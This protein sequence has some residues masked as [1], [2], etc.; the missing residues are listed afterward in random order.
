MKH[1]FGRSAGLLLFFSFCTALQLIPESSAPSVVKKNY[2][3]EIARFP[4][5]GLPGEH[6]YLA[7]AL[8]RLLLHT[9]SGVE[10][11]YLS[12]QEKSDRAFLN[13]REAERKK[14]L[15]NAAKLSSNSRSGLL[16][17]GASASAA[18]EEP[19][20]A[21][22]FIP[23]P[24][25][26][27]VKVL[28]TGGE[29]SE[30]PL[31]AADYCRKNSVDMLISGRIEPIGDLVYF[32]LSAY[33]HSRDAWERFYVSTSGFTSL[34]EALEQAKGAVREEVLGRPWSAL[35]LIT[36]RTDASIFID[37]N[38]SGIGAVYDKILEPGPHTLRV[39][40]EAVRR[41]ERFFELE[42]RKETRINIALESMSAP[43]L[44]LVSFPSG[45]DVY[46]SSRWVGKTPLFLPES[47]RTGTLRLVLNG[48]RTLMLPVSELEQG[49]N[50]FN[51]EKELYD[52]TGRMRQKK[53]SLYSAVGLFT[54]SLPLTMFSY[55][56]YADYWNQAVLYDDTGLSQKAVLYNGL[57]YGSLIASGV[58]FAHLVE[59]LF[60]YRAA[61]A[62]TF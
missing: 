36:D 16:E 35:T 42:E 17:S 48:Y 15:E 57:F 37:N 26:L 19:V 39:E 40:A 34:E 62:N 33:I 6:R 46:L 54:L 10:F 51:L 8:P 4:S 41:E 2:V 24:D 14:S 27:P 23:E 53:N 29:F 5:A 56:L 9:L 52:Y 59:S 18:D 25:L 3:V 50:S 47:G 13:I 44:G 55:S 32:S 30:L 1:G 58:L 38:L 60:D 20:E 21:G 43:V 61:G 7:E 22:E 28:N 11:R 31:D 49:K 45:A 12:G